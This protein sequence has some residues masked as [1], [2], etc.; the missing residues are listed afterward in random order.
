MGAP[1][2]PLI[3]PLPGWMLRQE[4][5]R[6]TWLAWLAPSSPSP[7]LP[8]P[9][10]RSSGASRRTCCPF[11]SQCRVGFV[12]T[13]WYVC[14]RGGGGRARAHAFRC[15]GVAI[16]GKRGGNARAHA[17]RAARCD[18]RGIGARESLHR[19]PASAASRRTPIVRRPAVRP[20]ERFPELGGIWGDG[21]FPDASS[22]KALAVTD[23]SFE[24]R[25][26]ARSA[27]EWREEDASLLVG[28]ISSISLREKAGEK[29]W[30]SVRSA[31]RSVTTSGARCARDGR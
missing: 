19:S 7:S 16:G 3:T 14:S 30:E 21:A 12:L 5:W 2:A 22:W 23:R 1:R 31:R 24:R 13:R 15:L 6:L 18:R 10:P 26:I 27:R 17:E 9:A 29:N 20:T 25:R 8:L 4:Q 11:P 28:A